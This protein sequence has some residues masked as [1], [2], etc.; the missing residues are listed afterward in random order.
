MPNKSNVCV[1]FVK[2]KFHSLSFTL[3]SFI[4]VICVDE[5]FDLIHSFIE[6]MKDKL[7]D[8]CSM[9]CYD[10]GLTIQFESGVIT[11]PIA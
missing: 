2:I 9:K 6:S 7:L 5:N 10:I 8:L 1:Y 4:A 11:G 3:F